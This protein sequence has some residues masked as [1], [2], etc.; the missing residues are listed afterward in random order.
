VCGSTEK[1]VYDHFY[2]VQYKIPLS[3]ENCTILCDR[4]NCGGA[5]KKSKKSKHPEEFFTKEQLDLL[6]SKYGIKKIEV[7]NV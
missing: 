6:Y 3:P 2:P 7:L 5:R 4:C 1:L